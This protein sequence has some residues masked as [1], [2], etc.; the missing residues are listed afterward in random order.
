MNEA[1]D[2][3]PMVASTILVSRQ[4]AF[5]LFDSRVT[6]SSVFSRFARKISGMPVKLESEFYVATPSGEVLNCKEMLKGYVIT[7]AGR[8]LGADLVIMDMYDFDVIQGMDWKKGCVGF[9]ASVFEAKKEGSQMQDIPVVKDY[10]DGAPV[11]FGNKVETMRSG[12]HQLKV[13]AED[14]PKTAFRT[15][16]EHYEFLVMPF[17]LT[18]APGAFMDLMNRVFNEYLDKKEKLFAKFKKC[19]FWLSQVAFLG[20]IIFDHGIAVDSN[21]VKA[22]ANWST[23]TS[24]GEWS[25]ERDKSFQ[26][27]KNRL[28]IA[29][30][31]TIPFS[32][33]GYVIYSDSSQEGLGC[34]LMQNGKD[35]DCVINYHHGKANVVADALSRKTTGYTAAL[36]TTQLEIT[37]D[38]EKLSIDVRGRGDSS[39]L[40]TLVVQ[41]TL[42]DRIKE[43]QKKDAEMGNILN[44]VLEG[45]ESNFRVSED[46]VLHL[47]KRVCIPNDDSI[48]KE[49]LVEAH[50]S[51]YSVYPGSTKMYQDLRAIYW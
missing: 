11:L 44:R 39:Y 50:S 31:L 15:R 24:V 20:H 1:E 32:S 16:Y 49:I 30:V 22:V 45:K 17:G 36:L 27:L 35:Y 19:E 47:G 21:K 51:P 34:V 48:K 38:F 41:P 2:A 13:R 10:A 43:C 5:T 23:P 3:A 4:L 28:V 25:D 18:N 40:T 12:Y 9:L 7:I 42:M 37:R 33:S 6:H 46:G 8:E 29:P 14:V 26:E